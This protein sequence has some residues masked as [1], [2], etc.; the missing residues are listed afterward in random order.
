[1]PERQQAQVRQI[2][3]VIIDGVADAVKCGDFS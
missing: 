2:M 1:M 3:R